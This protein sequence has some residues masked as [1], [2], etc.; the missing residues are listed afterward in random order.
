[1]RYIVAACSA[2]NLHIGDPTKVRH[3]VGPFRPALDW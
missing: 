3:E 2:C 1:M